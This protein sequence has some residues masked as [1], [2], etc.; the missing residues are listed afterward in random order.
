[1]CARVVIGKD[2]FASRSVASTRA[3][4]HWPN[5]HPEQDSQGP[6]L[7]DQTVLGLLAKDPKTD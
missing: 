3:D 2:T 6:L 1:M 7:A 4:A 5:R